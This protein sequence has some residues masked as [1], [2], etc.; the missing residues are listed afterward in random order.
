MRPIIVAFI[1]IEIHRMLTPECL[2][3]NVT[4]CTICHAN[5]NKRSLLIDHLQDEDVLVAHLACL[6]SQVAARKVPNGV[7]FFQILL[8]DN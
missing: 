5:F 7:E 1:Q 8:F 3:A 4:K 2:P 6:S